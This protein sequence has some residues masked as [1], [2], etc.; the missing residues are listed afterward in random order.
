LEDDEHIDPV[1]LKE[2][3]STNFAGLFMKKGKLSLKRKQ[4]FEPSPSVGPRN[5]AA[6]VDMN[7]EER[8][9]K[10]QRGG[11]NNITI[12]RTSISELIPPVIF[13]L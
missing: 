8:A 7:R 1:S 10:K 12:L 13:F 5:F 4:S 6:D 11:S 9:A 3:E 2:F